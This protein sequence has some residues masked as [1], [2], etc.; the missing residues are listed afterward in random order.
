MPSDAPTS[1]LPSPEPP[2]DA[3][4]GRDETATPESAPEAPSPAPGPPRLPHVETSEYCGP[5]QLCR[6]LMMLRRWDKAPDLEGAISDSALR[7]LLDLSFQ[8]SLTTEEGRHPRFRIYVG[9]RGEPA[10]GPRT[11]ARFEPPL[12][13][14]DQLLRRIAPS[15][16]SRDHALCVVERDRRLLAEGILGLAEGADAPAWG[17][18]EL[19]TGAG[20]PGLMVRVDGPGILRATEKGTW[21]LRAGR[22]QPV[23]HYAVLRVVRDWFSELAS[24]FLDQ[25][26]SVADLS[27]QPHHFEPTAIFDSVWSSVLSSA[28]AT[29]HGGAFAVLPGAP[30]SRNLHIT[31]R[32][33]RLDLM[34]AALRFWESCYDP[35]AEVDAADALRRG[36]TWG[37]RRR[38]L[39][40]A[41]RALADLSNVDGCVVLDR[42]LRLYGF[43]AEIRVA[44]EEIAGWRCTAA[45]P[46]TL[47][48]QEP[49]EIERFGT[50]HRSASRLCAAVPGTVVFVISQDGDLRVFY[51]LPDRRVCVWRNLGAWTSAAERW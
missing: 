9:A 29:Q 30:P 48:E 24:T 35:D 41:S 20:V 39:L 46:D 16:S 42:R 1:D 11:V 7:R 47:S 37:A 49:V 14:T 12:P 6:V 23:H 51:G 4:A 26:S 8:V 21:E 2:R 31:Y 28:L 50:R 44:D 22:I 33:D 19:N 15:V 36:R 17:S 34:K 27:H 5:D 38:R 3:S 45:H 18:P 13:L 43:G 10:A 25:T 32:A 40:S